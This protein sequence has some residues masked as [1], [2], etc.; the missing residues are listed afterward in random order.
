MSFNKVQKE[1]LNGDFVFNF[2]I[3]TYKHYNNDTYDI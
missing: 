1:R 3:N 2:S